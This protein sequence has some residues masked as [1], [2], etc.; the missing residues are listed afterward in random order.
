MC[1]LACHL[2]CVHV[3]KHVCVC[4]WTIA[5]FLTHSPSRRW[6]ASSAVVDCRGY[7]PLHLAAAEGHLGLCK[8]LLIKEGVTHIDS[9]TSQVSQRYTPSSPRAP[10][11]FSRNCNKNNL[12]IY[13]FSS[14][15]P[16]STTIGRA[17]PLKTLPGGYARLLASCIWKEYATNGAE[18]LPSRHATFPQHLS[19]CAPEPACCP[20]PQTTPKIRVCRRNQPV[21]AAPSILCNRFVLHA[22]SPKVGV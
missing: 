21:G 20:D 12:K 19:P 10:Q 2:A 3:W 11:L 8:F 22:N 14:W 9:Q 1:L 18:A 5:G 7:S 15:S 16:P 13:P 17:R 4:E 6:G